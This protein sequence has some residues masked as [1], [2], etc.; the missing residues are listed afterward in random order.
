MNNRDDLIE[1]YCAKNEPEVRV[2]E[3]R[4]IAHVIT[5]ES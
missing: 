5:V 1:V 2:V 3:A 4:T